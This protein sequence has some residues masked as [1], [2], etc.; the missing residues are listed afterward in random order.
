MI[1]F[2]PGLALEPRPASPSRLPEPPGRRPP[3]WPLSI[4]RELIARGESAWRSRSRG[5]LTS[6]EA[7]ARRS[8]A[9]GLVCCCV[10]A[11]QTLVP[12]I[13]ALTIITTFSFT[14]VLF[15]RFVC[16]RVFEIDSFKK[17][18]IDRC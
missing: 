8:H 12:Y 2:P 11:S 6:R 4:A 7:R 10:S 5:G 18:A 9:E 3:L 1:P 15:T 13:P 16:V 17:A 14:P